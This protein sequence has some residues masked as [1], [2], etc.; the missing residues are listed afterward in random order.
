[1][2]ITSPG[3][4]DFRT[5]TADLRPIGDLPLQSLA[6]ILSLYVRRALVVRITD[7][8]CAGFTRG[9]VMNPT[10]RIPNQPFYRADHT[11]ALPIT[12]SEYTRYVTPVR[13]SVSE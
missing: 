5:R 9:I 1:M 11:A 12:E 8:S 2:P 13:R 4:R 10:N 3:L 7:R 6:V